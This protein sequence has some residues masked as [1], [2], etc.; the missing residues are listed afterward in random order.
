MIDTRASFEERVRLS[1]VPTPRAVLGLV[2]DLLELGREQPLSLT[3]RDGTCFV[4]PVGDASNAVEVPLPKSV[5]RAVLARVAA[6]CN[7]QRPNSVSLSGGTGEVRV[8]TDSR[9]TL[10]VAFTNT[11]G[12]QR[13]QVN[14]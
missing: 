10:R 14:E 9:T 8:G 6:L 7:E 4:T 5:F 13:L 11:P 2:D 1:F 12:D 3:F